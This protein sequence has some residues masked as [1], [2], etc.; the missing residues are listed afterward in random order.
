MLVWSGSDRVPCFWAAGWVLHTLASRA[1]SF[2]TA[3][4]RHQL[5]LLWRLVLADVRTLSGLTRRGRTGMGRDVDRRVS[6]DSVV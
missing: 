5:R 3:D 1:T 4:L 2:I 6:L